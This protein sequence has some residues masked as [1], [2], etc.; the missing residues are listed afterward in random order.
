MTN[1]THLALVP[2]S[3][4]LVAL[5]LAG[6]ARVSRTSS[7]P[8]PIEARPTPPQP[9]ASRQSTPSTSPAQPA[10]PT[11]RT[12]AA[13]SSARARFEA[14]TLA[15]HA[16]VTRCAARRL[17]AEQ[18]STLDSARQLLIEAR[19]AALLGDQA[20]AESL[21]RE[22]RQLTRSLNCP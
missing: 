5:A 6:C 7:R 8:V 22:A 11:T 10:V 15:A 17:L 21:A 14:D 3:L 20:R 9:G 2:L 18:E 4:L 19:T 16:A 1:R 13:L 12:P